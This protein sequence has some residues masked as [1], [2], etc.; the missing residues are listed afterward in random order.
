MSRAPLLLTLSL[1]ACG[2]EAKAPPDSGGP[3][4]DAAETDALIATCGPRAAD[5]GRLASEAV[6]GATVACADGLCTVRL[7]DEV[8]TWS[9]AAGRFS[10]DAVLAWMGATPDEVLVA[11]G[12]GVNRLTLSWP[13]FDASPAGTVWLLDADGLVEA[14]PDGEVLRRCDAPGERGRG[15]GSVSF[16]DGT[17]L[18]TGVD[19]EGVRR[20]WRSS[21]DGWR[22]LDPGVS[23]DRA[24]AHHDDQAFLLAYGYYVVWSLDDDTGEQLGGSDDDFS[25]VAVCADRSYWVGGGTGI[26]ARCSVDHRCED[27]RDRGVYPFQATSFA[28]EPDGGLTWWFGYEDALVEHLSAEGVVGASED[29]GDLRHLWG[30]GAQRWEVRAAAR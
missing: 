19:A 3:L 2:P 6:P 28:C 24:V 21:L 26:L 16:V 10:G 20:M 18:V 11:A 8:S 29:P 7:P 1:P 25:Q 27:L 9:Y 4:D 23:P 12:E 5:G 17:L 15:E 13:S 22:L 30:Q 14:R